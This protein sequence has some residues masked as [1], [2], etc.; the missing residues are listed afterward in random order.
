MKLNRWIALT[1]FT[2]LTFGT[3]PSIDASSSC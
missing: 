1:T 3:I 2:V